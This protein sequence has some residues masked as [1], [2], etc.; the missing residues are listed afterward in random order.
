MYILGFTTPYF[1]FHQ[2]T[3]INATYYHWYAWLWFSLIC[4]V[5]Y[6]LHILFT[7]NISFEILSFPAYLVS[8]LNLLQ[9]VQNFN[10]NHLLLGANW[11]EVHPLFKKYTEHLAKE[12]EEIEG[13][14]L[15]TERGHEVI[16]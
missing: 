7:Y 6:T 11:E 5:I 16:F 1:D 9:G 10:N 2:L 15:K 8:F 4:W 13:K 12:M 3:S 14:C